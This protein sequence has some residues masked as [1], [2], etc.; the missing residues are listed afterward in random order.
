M[1]LK[2]HHLRVGQMKLVRS[3]ISGYLGSVLE[4]EPP[5]ISWNQCSFYSCQ[6]TN[7]ET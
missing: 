5:I 4:I 7:Q 2:T 1:L 6:Y 3:Q